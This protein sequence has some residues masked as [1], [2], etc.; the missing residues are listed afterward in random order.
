[1]EELV[2]Y[3]D[4]ESTPFDL[5]P[6]IGM[7]GQCVVYK[8][9]KEDSKPRQYPYAQ[10]TMTIE[11]EAGAVEAAKREFIEEV[12]ILRHAQ[13]I[14]VTKFIDAFE[15]KQDKP[16]LAFVMR[17][18]KGDINDFLM[19]KRTKP[20]QLR[21]MRE[22]F[23][24]LAGA[25]D[26]IHGLGIRH[27]DIKPKNIL[28]GDKGEALLADFGISRMGIVQ[29]L[30]TTVPQWARSRTSSHCAP[31]VENGSSRGRSADIFSLGCIFLE[32]LLA[33]YDRD[34]ISSLAE[35]VTDKVTREKSYAKHVEKLG[36]WIRSFEEAS[37][38][39]LGVLG[40]GILSLCQKM[41][42]EDR[43]G[44]PQAFEVLEKLQRLQP[45]SSGRRPRLCKCHEVL[46]LEGDAALVEACK[47]GSLDEVMRLI[48]HN[49]A[50][51]S[52]IGALHQAAA[53]NHSSIV[54]YLVGDCNV[55]VDLQDLSKQTALHCAASSG[56]AE[57]LNI[58]LY[59]GAATS[60]VDIE[61]RTALHYAAG[62]GRSGI[63]TI[64]LS[65]RTGLFDLAIEDQDGQTALHFAAKRGHKVEVQM[66]LAQLPSTLEKKGYADKSDKN[67]HTA[68]H[69]AAGYG[70]PEMVEALLRV[71]ANV[72]AK[73]IRKWT[74]L[75]YAARGRDAEKKCKEVCELLI[76][77]GAKV[78]ELDKNGK[79]AC[80][81]AN[82]SVL[83]LLQNAMGL[84]PPA[85]IE[86]GDR[87]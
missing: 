26:Y 71:N 22:W 56:H 55:P 67:K 42:Q 18:A 1:M 53:H 75:H 65:Q 79:T 25:V 63:I 17:A 9:R 15:I 52:A 39:K 3:K 50:Q 76:E 30:S 82:L 31:E 86:G 51:A 70:S 62:H 83:E 61:G 64:L 16:Q 33:C 49:E 66:L 20:D 38:A 54:G 72:H 47:A 74:A 28:V 2:T 87:L 19:G 32:L 37:N 34:R 68:L 60:I 85:D 73:D 77:R 13:H 10:K 84:F 57:I 27:R 44:R 45:S 36:D 12:K 78:H 4:Q 46:P 58:L 35:E 11:P 59:Y 40:C 43:D 8:A 29:T 24:C 7:G 41:L 5:G 69:F 21:L 80:W 6:I 14:H 48:S 81:D 23:Y